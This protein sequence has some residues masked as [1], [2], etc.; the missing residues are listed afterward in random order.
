V[1]IAEPD[2]QPRV[3]QL[4]PNFCDKMRNMFVITTTAVGR[5]KVWILLNLATPKTASLVQEWELMQSC[6]RRSSGL[7]GV[8]TQYVLGEREWE[9]ILCP[10]SP[11]TYPIWCISPEAE[12][13]YTGL[14]Y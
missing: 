14:G 8:M 10:Y 7:N 6:S 9:E 4:T 1:A 11:A 3:V 2:G 5:E 12:A 13:Q